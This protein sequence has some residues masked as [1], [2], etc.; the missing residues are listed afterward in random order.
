[1]YPELVSNNELG[2]KTVNYIEIIPILL[3]QMKNMQHEIDKL[4][5]EIKKIK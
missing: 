1:L 5:E 2:F 4:K 3:S